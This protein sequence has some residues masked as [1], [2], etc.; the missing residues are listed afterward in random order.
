MTPN[1]PLI[2][3]LA[4]NFFGARSL[5]RGLLLVDCFIMIPKRQLV[6]LAILVA[7]VPWA[8]RAQNL[9]DVGTSNP[10]SGPN[11]I[12]Q[13]ST[14]GNTQ[15]NTSGGFNYFTDNPNPPGQTFTT[16]TNSLVLTSVSIKTG[17]APLNS[18]TNGLGPQPF[19]LRIFS[20]AGGVASLLANYTST[21]NFSYSDGDWVRWNNLFFGLTTNATYAYTFQ[22]MSNGWGGLAVSSGNP[23]N[24]GEAALVPTSGGTVTYQ[25]SHGYDAVFDIGLSRV[26][27]NGPASGAV[28]LEAENGLLTGNPVPYVTTATSGYSGTGYV[29]GIRDSTALISWSFT[30]PP[31]LY[32][33]QVRYRSPNGQK[34]FN[35]TSNGHG[36]SGMFSQNNS[37]A[38]FDAG[39]VQVVPGANT[40]Q[41]GGGWAYYDIDSVS[42][43]PSAAP[44][45]PLPVPATLSDPQ[46]TFAARMLM[47]ELVADYGKVTWAGHHDLSDN[48]YIQSNTGRLPGFIEGDLIDYSPTRV[49]YGGMPANYTESHIALD[50]SGY[51]LGFC[52]HWNAPTN[53]LNTT[54]EP[55][56]RGFYTEATTFNF[57]AAL[58]NTNSPEYALLLRDID[59][60]A[61]QLKKVSSNN[62]PVL[63]RPLH[64][65]SGGWFWW[66][67]QGSGPF[68]ALW[69]LLYNRLTVY[70]NLHNLIWVCTNEDP[71]WYPGDDVVDILG[72]DGYPADMTDPL[73][74]DWLTLK[75]QFDGKKLI[76]LSEFGGVPDVERMHLFGVWFSYFSPWPG[77]IQS[78]PTGTMNRIYNSTQVITLNELNARPSV[79]VSNTL[80][81]NGSFRLAGT[82]PHGAG[83]HVL[84]ADSLSVPA[85]NWANVTNGTLTG[86]VL[87]AGDPQATNHAQRFYI[88]KV[89]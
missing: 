52:W 33:L 64:E 24:G 42:L 45:P 59:A 49:Q 27:T 44:P 9:T 67:A 2:A 19:Q 71:A 37:F 36:F 17:S 61:V 65:A 76:T 26:L 72:V 30:A 6:L 12:F 15:L 8:G 60:I 25:S 11:D 4:V 13:L 83:Y 5:P 38:L 89:P 85:D 87:M 53:L 74:S 86:G 3:G 55:W 20:V 79:I 47:A 10:V 66:G 28:T 41:I 69:R 51:V 34:G 54:A 48:N 14:N 22:R 50:S 70:H 7:A 35:G 84:A 32:E 43:T 68:K 77:F 46:A 82:G 16:G 63:W 57:A 81:G 23:Y 62:I 75:A 1:P 21:A 58:A 29:T 39:L 73:S 88:I 18:S 56:W 40:L 80:A 31:G 78:A